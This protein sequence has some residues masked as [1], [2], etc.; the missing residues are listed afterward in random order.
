MGSITDIINKSKASIK[1]SKISFKQKFKESFF[2]GSKKIGG[3]ITTGAKVSGK[4]AIKKAKEGIQSQIAFQKSKKKIVKQEKLRAFKRDV[5]ASLTP[6]KI[7][8][9]QVQQKQVQTFPDLL[10][11]NN[12]KPMKLF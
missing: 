6:R 10:G 5:R 12:N 4:F 1:P 7:K 9:K 11:S 3:V 8:Q 2:A